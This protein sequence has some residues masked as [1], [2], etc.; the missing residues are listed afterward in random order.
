MSKCSLSPAQL[1]PWPLPAFLFLILSQ[2]LQGGPLLSD[3]LFLYM[4]EYIHSGSPWILLCENPSVLC[5][6]TRTLLS[7]NHY[8]L[9][10]S[11]TSRAI[12]FHVFGENFIVTVSMEVQKANLP[13]GSAGIAISWKQPSLPHSPG[14]GAHLACPF[15]TLWATL[16]MLI[17]FTVC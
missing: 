16:I 12:L 14:C 5:Q 8:A 15:S 9:I 4:Y 7:F 2:C 1:L 13:L 11:W 3:S 10:S 6:M 17:Y